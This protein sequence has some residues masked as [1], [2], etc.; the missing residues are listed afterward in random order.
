[1]ALAGVGIFCSLCGIFVVRAKEGASFSQLLK[2]LHMGVWF[3]SA[4]V[5]SLQ[6]VSLFWHVARRT[7]RSP[8]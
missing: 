8:Q 1:M 7:L 2:G 5:R 3:A 4:L 6:V